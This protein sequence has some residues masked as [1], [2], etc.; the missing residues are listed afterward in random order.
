MAEE[1]KPEKW[2]TRQMGIVEIPVV[3]EPNGMR[4]DR[5]LSHQMLQRQC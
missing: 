3:K 2:A 1:D 4:E 5:D